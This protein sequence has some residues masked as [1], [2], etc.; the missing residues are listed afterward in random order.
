MKTEEMALGELLERL[1][2]VA[3]SIGEL[4][5]ETLNT[6]L[7][8]PVTVLSIAEDRA[9]LGKNISTAGKLHSAVPASGEIK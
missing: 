7:E 4:T 6:S 1:R 5:T 2:T 9:C 3:Q 8:T